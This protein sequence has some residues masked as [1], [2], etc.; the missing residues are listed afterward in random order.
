M[1]D[2]LFFINYSIKLKIPVLE[3]YDFLQSNKFI[4]YEHYE[5]IEQCEKHFL[6]FIKLK[7]DNK[8]FS[9]LDKNKND[10]IEQ[11][12]LFYFENLFNEYFKS[13]NSEISKLF[14][15]KKITEDE[16]LSEIF[17]NINF[18]YLKISLNHIDNYK[19]ENLDKDLLNNLGKLYS[20]AY[21]KI[22]IQNLAKAFKKDLSR[23]N[24]ELIFDEISNKNNNTRKIV[25]LYFFKAYYHLCE[26]YEG[27]FINDI[28]K[29][30]DFPFQELY[31]SFTKTKKNN[32]EENY[33]LDNNFIIMN[34]FENS[35]FPAFLSFNG[36]L[37]KEK[38][39]KLKLLMDKSDLHVLFC[40][41]INNLLSFY[42]SNE[43][44]KYCQ[45]IEIFK[46]RLIEIKKENNE[47]MPDMLYNIIIKLLNIN[48]FMEK[49]SGENDKIAK[50]NFLI[51]MH[52]LRFVIQFLNNKNKN[53]FYLNILSDK[54]KEF[55]NN[56]F[57]IGNL[58]FWDVHVDSYYKL[59][60][61]NRYKQKFGY[62]IC[63]CGYCYSI[64]QCTR[65][66]EISNCPNCYRKIGGI[67]H[68]LF[69]DEKEQTNHIRVYFN[70]NDTLYPDI[71]Y[72]YFDDYKREE[73]DKYLYLE[74]RGV[75]KNEI[76]IIQRYDMV[77][78]MNELAFRIL[79]FIL[80]STLFY[81]NL[82]ENL[83][84]N[85]LNEYCNDYFPNKYCNS[86]QLCFLCLRNDW[87]YIKIILEEKG[88]HNIHSFM[89]IIF[90]KLNEILKGVG[91]IEN[92]EQRN[93][94]EKEVNDFIEG[95]IND[96]NEY[97]KLEIK[98]DE[99]NNKLKNTNPNSF[100]EL[101]L[102]NFS[103]FD[104]IYSEN[105][106][107]NLKLFM[108]SNNPDIDELKISL[109]KQPE[110][111]KN[112]CL[113]NQIINNEENIKLMP[114]LININ[115]LEEYLYK[116]YDNNITRAKAKCIKPFNPEL[117]KEIAEDIEK[118]K[119]PFLQSWKN[120]KSKCTYFECQNIGD[121][122]IT[123]NTT[124]NYLLPDNVEMEGGIHLL[125]AYSNF[126]HWQNSFINNITSDISKNSPINSYLFQLQQKINVYEA[127]INDI[128]K[129]DEKN[130]HLLMMDMINKYSKRDIFK[131]GK[132]DFK[133]FKYPLKYD[134]YSFEK[135]LCDQIL[136]GIKY[137]KRENEGGLRFISYLDDSLI[138]KDSTVIINYM[139]KYSNDKLKKESIKI[140]ESFLDKNINFIM[141]IK[142]SC[143]NLM[144]YLSNEIYEKDESLYNIIQKSPSTLKLDELFNQFFIDYKEKKNLFNIQHLISIYNIIEEKSWNKI[145]SKINDDYKMKI[146]DY[147]KENLKNYL[148]SLFDS[149]KYLITKIEFA[150]AIRRFISRNLTDIITNISINQNNKLYDYILQEEL[151]DEKINNLEDIIYN[152]F[153][154][155]KKEI[156]LSIECDNKN[157][158]CHFCQNMKNDNKNRCKNCGQC[159]CGLRVGHALILYEIL[160]EL[161]DKEKENI[162]EN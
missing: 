145:K 50:E 81:S 67:D 137:F 29:I 151:W 90:D 23:F 146:N 82:S 121:L 3:K 152:I 118:F 144:R 108:H 157:K 113:L 107:P 114:N 18:E 162:F 54:C 138:I 84:T 88:I 98:Y 5:N 102:E 149:K 1:S 129:I 154:E 8:I 93:E 27:E 101:I 87:D 55:I 63:T 36:E 59:D 155:I 159:N 12:I 38:F 66:N 51:L 95:L 119:L 127:S 109:E 85:I 131:N 9:F 147:E 76:N 111:Q 86:D 78:N 2:S 148:L 58:P 34:N 17:E 37:K 28:N 124:L 143:E 135:D 52:S 65:P 70:R 74:N 110:N 20:I 79:N 42:F 100:K 80:Y 139:N 19:N 153:N 33:I 132:I 13:L 61:I 115:E 158:I 134:F 104:N 39:Q 156:N 116:K 97:E 92:K 21:I 7:K 15:S 68:K 94:I 71:P 60:K 16:Y 24:F 125:S 72:K 160:N 136:P 96:K 75:N 112:Y 26:C 83:D 77:R 161:I 32:N 141:E 53:N 47:L 14:N 105:D 56:N 140:L 133:G 91:C 10:I 35:F 69:V 11:I 57:I 44:E 6:D 64:G 41:L 30:E 120:I 49:I 22:Y 89:N 73:F 128:V 46:N 103:P 62:Y 142:N 106:F 25:K 40:L 123:E 31:D 45:L 4:E 122:D 99:F 117:S 150:N 43:K 130:I 126:I 48:K